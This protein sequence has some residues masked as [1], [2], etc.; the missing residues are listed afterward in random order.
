MAV[1]LITHPTRT[2]HDFVALDGVIDL[3]GPIIEDLSRPNIDGVQIRKA[4][5]RAKPSELISFRDYS[6]RDTAMAAMAEYKALRG[7]IVS[8][9]RPNGAGGTQTTPNCA[10]LDVEAIDGRAAAKIV[11]GLSTDGKWVMRVR[12]IVISRTIPA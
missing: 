5:K 3:A 7:E 9:A 2:P 10:V 12:W 1:P 8:I 11:G 6:S 4:A